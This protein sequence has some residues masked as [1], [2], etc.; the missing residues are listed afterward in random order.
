MTDW[1]T[2]PLQV[3]LDGQTV[4]SETVCVPAG[5]YVLTIATTL[6]DRGLAVETH[7]TFVGHEGVN[8]AATHLTLGPPGHPP[9]LTTAEHDHANVDPVL[10]PRECVYEHANVLIQTLKDLGY[11]AALDLADD[12]FSELERI[13]D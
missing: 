1:R 13:E 11:N 2:V 8:T 7:S 6:P 10:H 4:T 9:S 3:K 5:P 12:A